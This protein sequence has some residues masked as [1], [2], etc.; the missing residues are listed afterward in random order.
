MSGFL[1]LPLLRLA[2]TVQARD[3]ESRRASGLYAMEIEAFARLE[4]ARGGRIYFHD[5]IWWERI[6]PFYSWPLQMLKAFPRGARR[7]LF[8]HSA[9]GYEHAVPDPQEANAALPVMLLEDVGRYSLGC[10]SAKKRNQVRRG[11][12]KIRVQ[13]LCE[14]RDLVE[15]GIKINR[16]ALA[17]QEWGGDRSGYLD[18]QQWCEGIERAHVLGVR[19]SWGAYCSGKLVA[20]LRA[21]VLEDTAYITQAMSHT[22]YLGYYPNDALLHQFLM[23][24]KA[25][26]GVKGVFFGLSCAKPSLNEYKMR[27]G[28]EVV[29]IPIYRWLN[30]LVRRL[31]RFTRYQ[32]YLEHEI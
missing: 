19:E 29:R 16:S 5:G 24:C 20:Y 18:E 15:H 12:E 28:F 2:A 1:V 30:P 21:Y 13:R 27:F 8:L 23:D 7:P 10:L 25:R 17:R 31:A 4:V 9:V 14:I 6:K 32:H 22:E 3:G 26:P 11:L